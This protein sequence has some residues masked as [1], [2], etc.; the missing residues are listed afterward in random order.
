[1]R[2]VLISD[3]HSNL[4]TLQVPDGDILIHAGD[5]S[6]FGTLDELIAFNNALEELPHRHK[7][8]IAGNH[9]HIFERDPSTALKTLTNALYLQDSEVTIEGLRIYGSPW[10]PPSPSR[11]FCLSDPKARRKY[12]D[13]IPKGLDFLITHGPPVGLLDTSRNEISMGCSELREVVELRSP[14]IHVFGH[15]HEAY[16]ILTLGATTFMNTAIGSGR[17]RQRELPIVIDW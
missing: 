3:T 11:A 14:K 4:H 8:I 12:W 16:G 13:R 15:V 5:F 2:L 7:I 1:M 17:T 6:N 10:T 9:D